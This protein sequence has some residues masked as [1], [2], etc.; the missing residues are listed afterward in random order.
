MPKNRDMAGKP[1]RS[2]DAPAAPGPTRFWIGLLL[3]LGAIY[4]AGALSADHLGVFR[5]PGCGI[6]SPCAQA[7]ESWFGAVPVIGWPTAFLGLAFFVALAVAWIGSAKGVSKGFKWVTRVGAALSLMYVV[8]MVSGGYVCQWCLM[9]HLCNFAF[10]AI[11]ETCRTA[12]VGSKPAFVRGGVG[13]AAATALALIAVPVTAEMRERRDRALLEEDIAKLT[14]A[15]DARP[16]DATP[17][18]APADDGDAPGGDGTADAGASGAPAPD[19][20]PWAVRR[21]GEP[22]PEGDLYAGIPERWTGYEARTALPAEA[23]FS[24]GTGFVGN[25]LLGDVDAPIRIVVWSSYQ[26]RDCQR[27]E[28]EIMGLLGSRDDVSFSHRHFAFA[29]PCMTKLTSNKHP[30]SC[31][32]ARAAETAGILR[33]PEAFWE[34]H[35]WLFERGGGFTDA[36]IRAHLSS[37]GYDV[38]QFLRMMQSER[39]VKLIQP[40]VDLSVDMGLSFTPFIFVNGVQ[41]RGWGLSGGLTQYVEA[42]AGTNPPRATHAADRPPGRLDKFVGD[43]QNERTRQNM[44]SDFFRA[45]RGAPDGDV[46]I[47]AFFDYSSE[48]AKILHEEILYAMR[49]RSDVRYVVRHFPNNPDCNPEASGTFTEGSCLPAKVAEAAGLVGGPEAYARV[50]DWL[51]DNQLAHDEAS[52]RVALPSLGLDPDEVFALLDSDDVMRAIRADAIW[53]R[54]QRLRSPAMVL[55]NNKRV[56]RWSPEGGI[57]VIR[58]IVEKAGGP[59]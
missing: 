3:L 28:K 16:D 43:W 52:I 20:G 8:A 19:L 13:F 12:R 42:V 17:A 38:A 51:F 39:V 41:F 58:A 11:V 33:G 27:I 57:R 22:L 34:M 53:L 59:G 15:N 47:V 23:S 32:A 14:E 21:P 24:R 49:G 50:H 9:S 37:Q 40:E 46:E 2:D 36:E 31:W 6:D 4:A 29:A 7:Q 5:L 25:Y 55:I 30:N 44:G 26:C 1:A 18:D 48:N 56:P 54:Q 10:L 45:E 35:E